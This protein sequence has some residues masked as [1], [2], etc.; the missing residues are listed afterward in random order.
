MITKCEWNIVVVWT[1][2]FEWDIAMFPLR[3]IVNNQTVCVLCFIDLILLMSWHSFVV[4][5]YLFWYLFASYALFVDQHDRSEQDAF[6]GCWEW[7]QRRSIASTWT[8]CWCECDESD[9]SRTALLLA[10]ANRHFETARLLLQ[11]GANI[12][13]VNSQWMDSFA[14]R[15][16]LWCSG[17]CERVACSRRGCQSSQQS[18]QHAVDISTW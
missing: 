8:W 12:A 1:H 13:A 10:C 7:R 14:L 5:M 16:I 6:R 17:C 11:H 2:S 18:W 4:D 3:S 9:Y 15:V